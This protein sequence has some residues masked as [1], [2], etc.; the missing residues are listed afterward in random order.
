[1]L[2]IDLRQLLDIENF[3]EAAPDITRKSASLAIN[4]VLAGQG[5]TRYRKAVAA[6]V[7]FPS[8]YVNDKIEIGQRATPTSL[9]AS[10]IGR[11]R[12]TSLARFATSGAIGSKGGVSVRIKGGSRF[13]PSAFLVRLK[14]GPSISD[15]GY[16]IGLAVRL[17]EGMALKKKDTSRMVHLEQNVVLLYG[18]SVDQ[19]LRNEAAEA[20]TPEIVDAIATEF[21]RQ[22]QRLS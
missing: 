13:M 12:P 2:K 14:Q 21:F 5:L 19:I 18:P 20:T 22:F 9:V 4:D 10:V 16:N 15:D 6:E 1:M 17:K 7:E 8:G 11:Q 3:L